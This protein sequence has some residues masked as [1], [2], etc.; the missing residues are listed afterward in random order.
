LLPD[1]RSE[2][3]MPLIVEGEVLGVLDVQSTEVGPLGP[4]IISS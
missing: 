2:I 1:T 4:M 3:A